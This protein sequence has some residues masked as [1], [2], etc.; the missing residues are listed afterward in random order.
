MSKMEAGT[1]VI[2]VDSLGKR[3]HGLLTNVFGVGTPE[4]HKEKYGSWPCAN[5]VFIS[6]D[7]NRTD[8]YG[9]Q[10]ERFTSFPHKSSMPGVNG[11]FFLFPDEA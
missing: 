4:E 3:H 7:A 6:D 1:P 10:V 2:V 5:V 8:P 9:R 11:M